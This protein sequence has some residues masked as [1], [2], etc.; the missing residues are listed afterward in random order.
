LVG[1]DIEIHSYFHRIIIAKEPILRIQQFLNRE[2]KVNN[3]W[4]TLHIMSIYQ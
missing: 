1:Y 4:T 3:Q 2:G